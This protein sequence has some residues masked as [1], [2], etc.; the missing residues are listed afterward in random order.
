[1]GGAYPEKKLRRYGK[2]SL[3]LPYYS[4]FIGQGVWVLGYGEVFADFGF[5]VLGSLGRVLQAQGDPERHR[6]FR[7]HPH[8]DA[9]GDSDLH[10]AACYQAILAGFAAIL[11]G[12]VCLLTSGP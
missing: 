3:R 7:F 6:R 5:R 8:P 4:P 2:S 9:A 10:A 12:K 1:M 11:Q